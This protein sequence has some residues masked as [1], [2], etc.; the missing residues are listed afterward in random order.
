MSSSIKFNHGT[1]GKLEFDNSGMGLV[2]LLL[3]GALET[4]AQDSCKGN[5]FQKQYATD[6]EGLAKSIDLAEQIVEQLH[7]GI[8][9]IS[10]LA[11][12]ASLEEVPDSVQ[13]VFYLIHGLSRL[14]ETALSIKSDMACALEQQT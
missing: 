10:N 12:N 14:A 2:S 3:L 7:S 6:K 4:T 13:D 9:A 5:D 8:N 1:S 11:A